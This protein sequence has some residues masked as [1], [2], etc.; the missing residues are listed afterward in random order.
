MFRNLLII[1]KMMLKI[2][3][4]MIKPKNRPIKKIQIY[5]RHIATKELKFQT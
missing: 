2:K 4:M 5:K 3:I 1:I